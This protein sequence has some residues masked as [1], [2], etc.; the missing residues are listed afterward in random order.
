MS[1]DFNL[2]I[3]PLIFVSRTWLHRADYDNYPLMSFAIS[4]PGAATWTPGRRSG[5]K[6]AGD[7]YSHDLPTNVN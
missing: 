4:S 5:K 7:R 1:N 6:L 2:T 3:F